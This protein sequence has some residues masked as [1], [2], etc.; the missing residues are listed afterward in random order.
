VDVWFG[1][2]PN[3]T[4]VVDAEPNTTTVT[5]SAASDGRYYWQVNSYLDGSSSG[6][7]V[8]GML[9]TF[10]VDDSSELNL[11][12]ALNA[13]EDHITG[14]DPLSGT[15]IAAHKATID[16]DKSLFL[17]PARVSGGQT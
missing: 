9:L 4:K 7:P 10:Y 13:L 11:I 17:L 16:T 14:V 12:A 3:L 6:D 5:V 15:E 8:D 1:S 2:D